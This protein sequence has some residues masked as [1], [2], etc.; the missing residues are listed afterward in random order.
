MNAPFRWFLPL[1]L[2][3]SPAL[4]GTAAAQAPVEGQDY[5]RIA[6]G[7]PWQ[8]LDGQ[9]E[10]VEIFSYACHVPDVVRPLIPPCARQQPD[11][12]RVSHLP[13]AYRSRHPPP[14]AVLA[15]AAIGQVARL[16]PAPPAA[17]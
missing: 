4:P 12:V 15:P 1:L 7:E 11:D 10:V 8:P 9:V 3:L 16:H 5:V 13:A 17:V 2:A 14:T 6:G